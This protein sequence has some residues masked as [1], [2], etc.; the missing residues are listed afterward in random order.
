MRYIPN[1]NNRYIHEGS[2]DRGLGNIGEISANDVLKEREA[3]GQTVSAAVSTNTFSDSRDD[4]ENRDIY[5]SSN[6]G[7]AVS[8][9]LKAVVTS[10][11]AVNILDS[12][13][14]ILVAKTLAP[15]NTTNNNRKVDATTSALTVSIP[16]NS[17]IVSSDTDSL[18]TSSVLAA[19]STTVKKDKSLKKDRKSK[20]KEREDRRAER[21]LT[22]IAS[23]NTPLSG[24]RKAGKADLFKGESSVSVEK[25]TTLVSMDGHV[26][27]GQSSSSEDSTCSGSNNSIENRQAAKISSQSN[28]EKAR[29]NPPSGSVKSLGAAGHAKGS[30]A[31]E[32]SATVSSTVANKRDQLTGDKSQQSRV[33]GISSP[34]STGGV[35]ATTSVHDTKS[36][37]LAV[38]INTDQRCIHTCGYINP[39][40]SIGSFNYDEIRHAL[41]D[42][43][44]SMTRNRS[45]CIFV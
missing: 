34:L 28:K 25:Q 37:P 20:E 35:T 5:R 1:G 17:V 14:P 44:K 39:V 18:A 9:K 15:S 41:I 24:A 7:G 4:T 21:V 40:E 36:V 16:I 22:P 8:S 43:W 27:D 38:S 11:S 6:A 33:N 2:S 30:A 23:S 29:S 10:S 19:A 12:P 3:R 13:S 32:A 42:S 26:D 45:Q 31:L